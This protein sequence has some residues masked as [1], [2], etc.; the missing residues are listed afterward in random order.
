MDNLE[1]IGR[2][3][4]EELTKVRKYIEE[5]LAPETRTKFKQLYQYY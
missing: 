3:L 4:D 2:R 5:D 1:D